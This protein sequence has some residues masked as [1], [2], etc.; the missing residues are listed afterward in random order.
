MIK[1]IIG[2]PFAFL[3]NQTLQ[4]AD[5]VQWSVVSSQYGQFN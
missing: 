5:I 1:M 2:H 3:L 4:T